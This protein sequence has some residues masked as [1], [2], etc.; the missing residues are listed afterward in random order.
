MSDVGTTNDA[1]DAAVE[2]AADPNFGVPTEP[3]DPWVL[4]TAWLPTNDDPD[5]P[6]VTVSTVNELGAPDARTVLLS[7]FDRTGFYFHTD[8]NS[9]KA[10]H[11]AANP[12]V[13][14]TVLWP[15]FTRQLVIQG[16]AE[17]APVDEIAA[18][19]ISRSPYLKQLAWLNSHE[20]AQHPL[21]ERRATWAAFIDEHGPDLDQLAASLDQPASWIG[22]LVRPTRL[23]FWGS[24][25]DAASRR[26]EYTLVDGQ[27]TIGHLP[28]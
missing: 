23:T 4:L 16:T 22:Y 15:G 28:G 18:A 27:W 12:H 3:A 10:S 8:A 7:E 17:V 26:T 20:F 9:R 2:T 24:N 11:I 14:V 5:R 21:E 13:A 25:P 1:R 6:Q 19:Y